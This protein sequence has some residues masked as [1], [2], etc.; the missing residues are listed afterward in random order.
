MRTIPRIRYRI[1]YLAVF[2]ILTLQYYCTTDVQKK[3]DKPPAYAGL[4]DTV[5]YVGMNTCRECHESIYNSYSHTGMGSS[6]DV[7][8]RE[9]SS[10]KFD[11]HALVYDK[12]ADFFYHPFWDGD[13]LKVTEFRLNMKDTVYKR[14]ET[15]SYI[16]GSGQ[17]TNSHIMNKNGFLFQVP[18]TFYTQKDKWDLA[19]G[20]ENGNNSRFSRRIGLECMSCHNAFPE[21]VLG[22]ENK[23]EQVM[24]GI[25][26]EQCHGPG[27]VHVKL[28]RQG[29]V[30][31]ISQEV[32][33]SI[34]NPAK[35]PVNLQ[36]DVCQRCHIQGNA[37]L[38]EGRSFYDFRPGMPLSSVMNV[39]MPVFKG[40]ENEHIMASH[41]ERLKQSKCY[42]RTVQKQEEMAGHDHTSELKPYKNSLTCVT[43]HNPHVSV[44][45]TDKEIFNKACKNCHMAG[46][47]GLCTEDPEILAG[48]F[49]QCVACHMPGSGATDIPHVRVT[50]HRIAVPVS[51]REMEEVKKF[52]GIACINN[53]DVPELAI[54]KAYLAYYEKF[55]FDKSVLD[56]A[57]KYLSDKTEGDL[58]K[59][60]KP[61]IH[62]AFLKKDYR[63]IITYV[64]K[65]ADP[66]QFLN[67]K[68]FSNEDAW[69]C[70]RIA[71][72]FESEENAKEA[73]TY[74]T[75]AIELAP[76]DLNF[77]NKFG[78]S[79]MANNQAVRA[80][81]TF[82]FIVSQDPG[83]H[84]ALSN[85]GFL[86][87]TLYNDTASA[88]KFYHKALNLNPDYEQAAMNLAGLYI[89][90]LKYSE[91]ILILK[92]IVKKNPLNQKAKELLVQIKSFK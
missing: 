69:C 60:F 40:R 20:F 88:A 66:L 85:L 83:Q 78:A 50:D 16:V 37:V 64:G 2:F 49:Y 51:E 61:L 74:Y 12:H 82:E 1:G 6:F 44:K 9:K 5:E 79:L 23:Y 29:H 22:S 92:G 57:G 58:R 81:A 28:K 75:R 56:S 7:A 87:L 36:F 45:A 89:Y 17:H 43:C 18:I 15:V 34:V 25:G 53:S 73:L 11:S 55:N 13:S 26:C 46:K 77:Q 4:S 42:T 32:D 62:L 21:F 48:N 68:S 67:M 91:A 63:L 39:F 19:P 59:N 65:V 35:L 80:K 76:F 31:D 71:A 41:A 38:N 52:V 72:A 10:A 47:E 30:V 27:E 33:F 84:Q 86:Y 54:G 70:Y 90:S 3:A 8:S 24:N 14:T